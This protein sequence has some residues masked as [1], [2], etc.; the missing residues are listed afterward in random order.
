[1]VPSEAV[2]NA[3][4]RL[5]DEKK[6]FK[7]KKIPLADFEKI[8]GELSASVSAWSSDSNEKAN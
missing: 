7:Q 4:F 3:L 1:M 6:T 8:T 5:K 2:F